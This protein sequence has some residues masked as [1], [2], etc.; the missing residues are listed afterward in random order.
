MYGYVDE[1]PVIFVDS[2][3]LNSHEIELRFIDYGV[4]ITHGDKI[5]RY[6]N[7]LWNYVSTIIHLE[8]PEL[9]NS[10]ED[11]INK[12][13]QSVTECEKEFKGEGCCCIKKLVFIGHGVP[14]NIAV[15]AGLGENDLDNSKE[16]YEL[17]VGDIE[18]LKAIKFCKN[19]ESPAEIEFVACNVA[20]GKVGNDFLRETSRVLGVIA[21]GYDSRTFPGGSPYGNMKVT[22]FETDENGVKVVKVYLTWIHA[23]LGIGDGK[24]P[25]SLT[26]KVSQKLGVFFDKLSK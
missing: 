5:G 13:N 12:A 2:Y 21:K 24:N 8:P 20:E 4:E 11:A 16:H 25:D 1:S 10:V 17:N 6:Y 18:L 15:G 3:G 23:L 26:T 7:I 19:E 22:R 9:V 14:G